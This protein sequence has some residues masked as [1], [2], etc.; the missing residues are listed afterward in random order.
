MTGALNARH[1]G[2]EIAWEVHGLRYAG[3][4]WGEPDAPGILALHG[5]LDNAA[6]FAQLAPLLEGYYVVAPDL[7]GHGLS[8]HRAAHATYQIWDDLPELERIASELGWQRFKLIGHSRGAVIATLLASALPERVERLVL[9]DGVAPEPV[10]P[11]D[12]PQQ[13]ARAMSDKAQ[14]AKRERRVYPQAELAMAA[15]EKRGLSA[16]A[17]RVITERSLQTVAGGVT[18]RTDARL[19]GASAVKMTHEQSNAV[20][21]ALTMPTCLLVAGDSDADAQRWMTERARE[22]IPDLQVHTIAGGHHF[23]LEAG[24]QDAAQRINVFM[25]E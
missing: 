4:A 22:Q 19:H 6:S 1:G 14:I 11:G 8:D 7:S 2:R 9:L 25:N 12:F 20:L 13:L 18:W 3:L 10:A 21:R 24:V 16:A 5:W 17:A 15:R 23:H